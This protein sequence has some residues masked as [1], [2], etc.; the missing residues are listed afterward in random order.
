[1]LT[2][3]LSLE[4]HLRE[5]EPQICNECVPQNG[6]TNKLSIFNAVMRVIIGYGAQIWEYGINETV[7]MSLKYFVKKCFY[8]PRNI[9]DFVKYLVIGLSP[10]FIHCFKLLNS[11]NK[12]TFPTNI[13]LCYL[14]Y[15]NP[16]EEDIFELCCNLLYFK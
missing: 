1:M 13:K 7:E 11:L 6:A 10:T 12:N 5:L 16:N 3:G 2:S 14:C 15:L 4:P 8:L 9:P